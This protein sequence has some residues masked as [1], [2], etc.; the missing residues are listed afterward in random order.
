VAEEEKASARACAF[1]R[2]EDSVSIKLRAQAGMK[3]HKGEKIELT[4][5]SLKVLD[6]VVSNLDY[7]VYLQNVVAVLELLLGAYP[8]ILD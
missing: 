2:L 6:T 7:L 5:K 4:E 1:A 3:E 8:I